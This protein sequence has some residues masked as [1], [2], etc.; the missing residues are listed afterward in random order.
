MAICRMKC[1][2]DIIFVC[3]EAN[4]DLH[5][6]SIQVN[7]IL[8]NQIDPP[9]YMNTE[10]KQVLATH[11]SNPRLVNLYLHQS[12]SRT[13]NPSTCSWLITTRQLHCFLDEGHI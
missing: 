1:F 11:D 10:T 2:A 6:C 9:V 3:F 5:C 8:K 7:L 13:L 4:P 12:T